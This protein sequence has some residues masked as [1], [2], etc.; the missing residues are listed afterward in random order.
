MELEKSEKP[1]YLVSGFEKGR[2]SIWNHLNKAQHDEEIATVL[3]VVSKANQT[4][5]NVMRFNDEKSYIAW[6]KVNERRQ[7]IVKAYSSLHQGIES[8]PQSETLYASNLDF[9]FL[10]AEESL[11]AKNLGRQRQLAKGND[12]YDFFEQYAKPFE[13][14]TTGNLS[15]KIDGLSMQDLL[16]NPNVSPS[17]AYKFFIEAAAN[18]GKLDF[19][20]YEKV[21]GENREDELLARY[22][23]IAKEKIQQLGGEIV[24]LVEMTA[25]PY[26]VNFLLDALHI[27]PQGSE[28]EIVSTAEKMIKRISTIR[29]AMLNT[30]FD[31]S[32]ADFPDL[33]EKVTEYLKGKDDLARLNAL[34]L[35]LL[36]GDEFAGGFRLAQSLSQNG[37]ANAPFYAFLATSIKKHLEEIGSPVGSRVLLTREDLA[38]IIDKDKNPEPRPV[39]TLEELERINTLT[40]QKSSRKDYVIDPD[41]IE[42]QNLIPST[43]ISFAFFKGGSRKFAITF[44]YENEKGEILS[45]DFGFDTKKGYFDWSFME[46]PEDPEMQEMKDTLMLATREILLDVKEQAE[47]E[48]QQ[49]QMEKQASAQSHQPTQSRKIRPNETYVPRQKEKSQERPQPLTPIQEILQSEF[50]FL[51]QPEQQRIKNQIVLSPNDNLDKMMRNLSEADKRLAIEGIEEYNQRGIG[52]FKRLRYSGEER[53]PLFTLRINCGSGG[54]IRVLMHEISN[55]TEPNNTRAFEIVDIDYRKNIYRRRRLE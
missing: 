24:A 35:L 6:H 52:Q 33:K 43:R 1:R 13:F 11:L 29:K 3:E 36:I 2:S 8:S 18:F 54:G 20:L 19:L 49:K 47:A 25:N 4:L 55:P 15:I 9:I 26:M 30:L 22:P 28:R 17:K 23:T 42:W 45:L 10:A 40:I 48:Y 21:L 31:P 50:S 51:I 34:H 44:D 5:S 32:S 46:D 7:Q 27:Q 38:M 12:F 41:A 16:D 53:T 39:P 37:N 14:V